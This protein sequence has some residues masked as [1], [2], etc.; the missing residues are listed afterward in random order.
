MRGIS[1]KWNAMWHS[2]P[3]PKYVAHVGRPLVRLGEQH[4][5]LVR[6][7]EL[8]PHPLQHGVRLRQVLVVR[9]LAHAQVRHRVEPQRVDAEVEPELHHVDHR[10]DDRRVVVIEIGLVREEAVPV[11]LPGDR[12]VG[13]VRFLGVGE[14]DPRLRKL[15][16]GVA[17][18][19]ELALGRSRRRVPRALEPRMLVRRVV[20]DQLDQHLDVPL[21][22]G[23]D[24]RLEVVER[25]V[26]R[27]DVPVVGD[28]VAVVLAAATGRTAAARGR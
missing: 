6:G 26:A 19:V 2:S 9:A 11:V 27:V 7:V 22:R 15:L 8:A 16:V 1:G 25:A 5:V 17:P 13:P 4:P 23:V 3:S 20:D 21:V 18:D 28:V 14:D 12:I 24:E 10:V